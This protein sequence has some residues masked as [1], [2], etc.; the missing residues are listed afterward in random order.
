[1][2]TSHPKIGEMM[3]DYE[4][5]NKNFKWDIPEDYTIANAVERV[6]NVVKNVVIKGEVRE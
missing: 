2:H 1:M 6:E 5:W 4:E 3:D